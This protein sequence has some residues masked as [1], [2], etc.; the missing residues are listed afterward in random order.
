MER[1]NCHH[2]KFKVPNARVKSKVLPPT[3]STWPEEGA[4]V[5]QV[6]PQP[7]LTDSSG[8]TAFIYR[9][10][11]LPKRLKQTLKGNEE[12]SWI[13]EA[14]QKMQTQNQKVSLPRKEQKMLSVGCKEDTGSGLLNRPSGVLSKEQHC[15]Q[16][17]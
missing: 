9:H 5:G 10:N 13:R 15:C 6:G 4:V 3:P 7:G 12:A 1:Y 17:G 14:Y 8:G 2:L 16:T 11:R